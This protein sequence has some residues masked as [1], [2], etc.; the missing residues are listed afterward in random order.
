MKNRFT[1][2]AIGLCIAG[3]VFTPVSYFVIDSIPLTAI[4]ISVIIVGITCVILDYANTLLSPKFY[5]LILNTGLENTATL[6]EGL[7]LS[8]KAVYLPSS[9]GDGYQQALIPLGGGVDMNLVKELIPNRMIVQY[10]K[11]PEDRAISVITPGSINIDRIETIPG[12]TAGE[13]ETTINYILSEVLEIADSASVILVDD[14]VYVAVS[15]PKLVFENIYY[16]RCM[17]S[18]IAS[19]IAAISS[20][21]LGRPVLISEEN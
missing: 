18:P 6:L 4:G 16:Y 3:V 17:G 10:G 14:K 7:G 11:N 2:L 1:I 20:E 13:I 8:D 12:P 15:N 21:A 19:I 5:Q 9:M